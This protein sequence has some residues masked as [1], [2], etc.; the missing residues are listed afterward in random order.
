MCESVF[1]SRINFYNLKCFERISYGFLIFS[2]VIRK[3]KDVK[4]KGNSSVAS[5]S[6]R[7]VPS[8][9]I[10]CA[11]QEYYKLLVSLCIFILAA[12]S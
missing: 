5:C 3:C 7:R 10:G 9:K 12:K 1:R 4:S 8:C 6:N 11:F 2:L